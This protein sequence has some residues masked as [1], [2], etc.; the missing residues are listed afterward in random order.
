MYSFPI[1]VRLL[2]AKFVQL[3]SSCLLPGL[4]GG[5]WCNLS[6]STLFGCS[7]AWP[8]PVPQE[9]RGLV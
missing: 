8:H 9:G 2:G 3:K 5:T 1:S 4:V 7:L 6:S